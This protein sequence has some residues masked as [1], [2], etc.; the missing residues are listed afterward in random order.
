MDK[1]IPRNYT[2]QPHQILM[3]AAQNLPTLEHVEKILHKRVPN[4]KL[5]SLLT[6]RIASFAS[7]ASED[8][9]SVGTG[10][11]C[12]ALDGWLQPEGFDSPVLLT[13]RPTNLIGDCGYFWS[14]DTADVKS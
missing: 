2:V 1:G 10:H 13:N 9:P 4:H 7:V 12:E 6:N 3:A 5:V 14:I 11:A 8:T